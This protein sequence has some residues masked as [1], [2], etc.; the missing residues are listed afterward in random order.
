M[1]IDLVN[2]VPALGDDYCGLLIFEKFK[3]VFRQFLL[4]IGERA[5]DDCIVI[6]Q[7]VKRCAEFAPPRLIHSKLVLFQPAAFGLSFG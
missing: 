3:K 7:P 6:V 1:F 2:F 4:L 5:S